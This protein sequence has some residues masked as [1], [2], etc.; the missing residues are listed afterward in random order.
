MSAGLVT[1][2]PGV[3]CVGPGIAVGFLSRDSSV[4]NTLVTLSKHTR[5]NNDEIFLWIL[6]DIM[7][8][9]KDAV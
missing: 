8:G 5:V 4:D 6:D 9:D 7:D 2:L 3:G 1:T